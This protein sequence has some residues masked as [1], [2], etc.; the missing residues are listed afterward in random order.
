MEIHPAITQI[1]S[2]VFGEELEIYLIR[3]DQNALI[4]T[5]TPMSPKNDIAPVLAELG[6]TFEDIDL[7]LNT[8][9]HPDHIGGN[10][11]IKEHGETQ[12]FLHCDDAVFLE[13][14]ELSFDIYFAP[15]FEAVLGK[16][17]LIEEKSRFQEMS[18]K[19][20]KVDR[21][22]EDDDNI[23]LGKGIDLRVIHLPGHTSGS[24]GYYWEKEDILFTGDSLPGLHTDSGGLPI[25]YDLPAYGRSIKR[26][27][28][29]PINCTMS[30]HAFRGISSGPS[31]I[32]YGDENQ[33]YIEDSLLVYGWLQKA[34]EE[35][36][37]C[38]SRKQFM[39]LADDFI[40][41]IPREAGFLP[42]SQIPPPVFNVTTVLAALGLFKK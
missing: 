38:I 27:K 18:G 31:S 37:P 40:A 16:E 39:E 35:V 30:A 6:L 9:G 5:G 26:L 20:L 29:L 22:L 41:A 28:D 42:I 19:D 24:I 1:H 32:R 7:I 12:I 8:H 4:D 2:T 33:K 11:T 23:H 13:N 34:A 15:V 3:G 36:E 10:E 17:S 25:I 14:H 21:F